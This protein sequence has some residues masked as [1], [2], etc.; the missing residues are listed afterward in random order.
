MCILIVRPP[1]KSVSRAHLKESFRINSDGAGFMFNDPKSDSVRVFKGWFGFRQFYKDLRY[2]ERAYPQSTFVIHMRIGTSGLKDAA[3]CHPFSIN[4]K[5]GFAHNG[6]LNS[7]GDK[8]R[9]DTR[10][11]VEDVLCKLPDNFWNDPHIMSKIDE[12]ATAASSK[13]VLLCN[14]GTYTIFNESAGHWRDGVWFSNYS[15]VLPC[16]VTRI[17]TPKA[18]SVASIPTLTNS[19]KSNVIDILDDGVCALCYSPISDNS[20]GFK[21][22]SLKLCRDCLIHMYD[23]MQISCGYCN[24]KMP[25]TRDLL[26]GKQ[27]TCEYCHGA[28]DAD[29]VAWQ[30]ISAVA[31]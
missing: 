13:F 16:K 23:N 19:Y 29:D 10:E 26:F 18:K 21:R 22:H 17:V 5:A 14:T 31:E 25:L 3:N 27:E 24:M 9:S 28:I 7:L 1:G 11:F 30:L 12:C 15:Y 8:N 4:E 6:I 2:C 20:L